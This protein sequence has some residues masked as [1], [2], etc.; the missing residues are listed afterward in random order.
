MIQQVL[1][2]NSSSTIFEGVVDDS[3]D[4]LGC[5]PWTTVIQG[6]VNDCGSSIMQLNIR[7]ITDWQLWR[8]YVKTGHPKYAKAAQSL[9]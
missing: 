7:N 9:Q 8:F 6:V 3:E 4:F 2:C 5:A 1:R